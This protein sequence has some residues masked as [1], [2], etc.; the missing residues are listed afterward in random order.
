[1]K[2]LKVFFIALIASILTFGL[3]GW[4]AGAGCSGGQFMA[5]P[6]TTSIAGSSAASP[7][8]AVDF[9]VPL[10]PRT[11]TPPIRGSTASTSRAVVNR[12]WPTTAEN[13]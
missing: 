11:S 6:R 5:H 9:A 13:G 8:T 10:W 1:M 3:A 7:R 2:F 4:Q 12:D